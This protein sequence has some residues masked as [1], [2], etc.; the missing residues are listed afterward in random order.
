M[1]LQP[2]Q[3]DVG[4]RLD[5]A[6]AF[7]MLV[8][9]SGERRQHPGV[10]RIGLGQRT[11]RSGEVTR[12]ARVDHRHCQAGWLQGESRLELVAAGGFQHRQCR[13]DFLQPADQKLK[14]GS[15]VGNPPG[16]RLT[17][18]GNLQRLAGD[19]DTY[20][21]RVGH[22]P[23]LPSLSMRTAS[24]YNRSGCKIGRSNS[25]AQ[26]SGAGFK[27]WPRGRSGYPSWSEA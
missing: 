12:R 16:H 22:V 17:R 9:H 8:K 4:Q 3:L 2:L 13:K 25:G 21:N 7:G 24:T 10:Q 5:E 6:V 14:P 23:S 20:K 27:N 11:R 26:C 18:T 19:I 1:G 15:V